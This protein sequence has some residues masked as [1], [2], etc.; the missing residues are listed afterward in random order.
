MPHSSTGKTVPKIWWESTIDVKMGCG[1]IIIRQFCILIYVST[2]SEAHQLMLPCHTRKKEKRAIRHLCSVMKLQGMCTARSTYFLLM[3][4]PVVNKLLLWMG[5]FAQI[6][7][8]DFV[9]RLQCSRKSCIMMTRTSW[10]LCPKEACRIFVCPPA[11]SKWFM[12]Q[13][14]RE[15]TFWG[16]FPS[17]LVGGSCYLIFH[18]LATMPA[19]SKQH[20]REVCL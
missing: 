10:V 6:Q 12:A 16:C 17:W 1:V 5:G 18:Q 9:K 19:I 11:R 15:I 8:L 13:K 3:V 14:T 2:F 7:H 20:P 4:R